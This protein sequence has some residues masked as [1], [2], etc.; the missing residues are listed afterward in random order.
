MMH[1]STGI[2]GVV[3]V[4]TKKEFE[5]YAGKVKKMASRK[6]FQSTDPSAH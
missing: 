4:P 1:L 2:G 3:P 6:H 5:L